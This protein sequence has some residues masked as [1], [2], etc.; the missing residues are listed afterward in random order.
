[1]TQAS[2]FVR[3]D[4]PSDLRRQVLENSKLVIESLKRFERIKDIRAERFNEV[5]RLKQIF[6]ELQE[7]AARLRS[8][9]PQPK[10]SPIIKRKFIAKKTVKMPAQTGEPPKAEPA[11]AIPRSK[12]LDKLE[13]ELSDI[14]SK[15]S[16]LG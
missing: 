2:Y 14:E 6:S 16:R 8:S 12:D 3:I 13:T 7:L 10:M 5:V 9:L 1:M 4:D 15:L 11:R